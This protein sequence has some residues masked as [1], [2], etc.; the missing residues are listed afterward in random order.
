M[1]STTN[2]GYALVSSE[3]RPALPA[4]EKPSVLRRTKRSIT[5]ALAVTVGL[6]FVGAALVVTA[7]RPQS[8]SHKSPAVAQQPRQSII[9]RDEVD[10]EIVT[11]PVIIRDFDESHPDFET[12]PWETFPQFTDSQPTLGIVEKKLGNDGKP[13]YR[14]NITV[15]SAASFNQWYNTLPGINEQFNVKLNLTRQPD[16]NLQVVHDEF[17]PLDYLGHLHPVYNHKFWFTMEMHTVFRYHGGEVFSFDGDDDLWVFINGSLAI[18]L[19]GMHRSLRQDVNLDTLGLTKGQ[20]AS[21]DL[22]YAERHTVESHFRVDT[23]IDFDE[24]LCTDHEHMLL[25]TVPNNDLGGPDGLVFRGTGYV[26]NGPTQQLELA[27][28]RGSIYSPGSLQNGKFGEYGIIS[29]KAGSEVT[30]QFT[31]QDPNTKTPVILR[32]AYFSF[33][34]LDAASPGLSSE[35]VEIGGFTTKVLTQ[36]TQILEE[37]APAGRTRFST[38]A[39]GTVDDNPQDPNLLTVEQKNRVVTL[40]FQDTSKIE[41]KFACSVGTMD[42]DFMFA[43]SPSLLC[44]FTPFGPPPKPPVTHTATTTMTTT[45]TVTTLEPEQFCVIDIRALNFRLVCFTEKPWWM[46]WK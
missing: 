17:F 23:T 45:Q 33:L 11:I 6:C 37:M 3:T 35:S 42:C 12:R 21:L 46:F 34:D 18:D 4:I 31:F 38:T 15:D 40:E 41:A 10:A 9:M 14:G 22:F 1:S 19:G 30:L 44:S 20:V 5:T 16:G 13:V 26:P 32:K 7:A 43:A 29:V 2:G 39:V 27:I 8:L 36:E 28:E 25:G 24:D